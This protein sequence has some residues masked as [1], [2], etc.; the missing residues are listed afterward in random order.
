MG[1][2]KQLAVP[3]ALARDI[4]ESRIGGKARK[5]AELTAMGFSVPMGFC[6]TV[7]AYTAYVTHNS[8][9]RIVSFELGR[10]PFK[11]MRW[12]EL[13]DAALRIRAGFQK[14]EITEDVRTQIADAYS[15]LGHNT[16]VA[17]RSSAPK[18]DTAGASFAGLHESCVDVQGLDAVFEA[19]RTVWASLWSDSALL[20]Q[21]ELSL[22]PVSSTMAV[23]VQT[24]AQEP[25]SGVAFGCDPRNHD[26]NLC[27][28]E[29]VPGLCMD[30]VDGT[31]DPDRWIVRKPTGDVDTYVRGKRKGGTE[32]PLLEDKDIDKIF[33][34]LQKIHNAFGWCPDTEWT[35]TDDR[36]TLLQA[37]PI[38]TANSEQSGAKAYY[39][40]LRPGEKKLRDLAQ[41]VAEQLIPRLEQEGADLASEDFSALYDAELAAEISRRLQILEQ[42]ENIYTEYFIPFAHGVRTLGTFY[43]DTVHPDDPYEFVDLLRGEQMI[44]VQRNRS[45]NELAGY[46]SD[47][48]SVQDYLSS[49]LFSESIS[50]EQYSDIKQRI[51]AVPAGPE[52]IKRFERTR[53]GYLD[54][55]YG[56]ERLADRP[57][58]LMK[59]V[60]EMTKNRSVKKAHAG[61]AHAEHADLEKKLFDAVAP[62]QRAR[63]ADLL[64]IGRLSWRLR[65]DDNLLLGRIQSQVIR[66]VD[67]GLTRLEKAGRIGKN[68][69]ADL[70][71]AGTV[72]EA[73]QDWAVP[74]S[75]PE[76]KQSAA[77]KDF[78]PGGVAPRQLRGQP[79]APGIVS[80][81]ARIVSGPEDLGTFRAGEILVC[82]AIQPAMTHLVPLASAIVERRGGMLIHGAIIAREM[83]IPCVNG[84]PAAAEILRNGDIV[85]VDGH[86]GIVYVGEPEFSLEMKTDE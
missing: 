81:A 75:L 16:P 56:N 49:A 51:M 71:M 77:L 59:T 2:V 34:T 39:L 40:T 70:H 64:R 65:D 84:V 46:I 8:L 33:K 54:I 26:S 17:V 12:E 63:A 13:W 10:K 24:M 85:T 25:V 47:N 76:T 18:E 53:T 21:Q 30:L 28:I 31:V 55:S 66:A 7:D 29:A 45:F 36:F 3:L 4:P 19:L 22:D 68:V 1:A 6:I 48:T 5:L 82:D 83:G 80:G 44:S 42:W 74:V 67:E 52:F 27:I 35:G 11:D 61:Q 15:G 58:M 79:A 23:L 32:K 69:R 60:F 37:R 62:E 73:L 50:E 14:G 72:I 38:T 9:N 78:L 43:N 41:K 57:V 86:L 20:Y